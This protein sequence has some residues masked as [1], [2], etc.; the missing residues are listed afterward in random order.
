MSERREAPPRL[1]TTAS[2]SADAIP[3][4]ASSTLQLEPPSASAGLGRED[5]LNAVLNNAQ[6]E[7]ETLKR[8]GDPNRF[9]ILASMDE[10]KQ[11]LEE[12]VERKEETCRARLMAL[13]ATRSEIVALLEGINPACGDDTWLRRR[14]S[15]ERRMAEGDREA[16]RVQ[17]EIIESAVEREV[18]EIRRR[19]ALVKQLSDR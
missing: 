10:M 1:G 19:L 6:L 14:E 16:F 9:P 2:E 8:E 7:G 18:F 17:L 13:A 3:L 15:L 5:T 12:R 4:T 11:F